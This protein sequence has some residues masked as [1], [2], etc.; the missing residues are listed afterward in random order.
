MEN[1][2]QENISN[3]DNQSQEKVYKAKKISWFEKTKES[4][5]SWFNKLTSDKTFIGILKIVLLVILFL[6]LLPLILFCLV[7]G[8]IVYLFIKLGSSSPNATS[9]QP[10]NDKPPIKETPAK[11]T[12][13][14]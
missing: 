13:V 8:L 2:N 14:Q 4:F 12:D 9:G 1:N 10:S 5:S 7:V 6:L 3:V 11:V